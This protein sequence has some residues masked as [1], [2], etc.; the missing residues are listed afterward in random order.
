[1]DPEVTKDFEDF[2]KFV[3]SVRKLR[4]RCNA[5][6]YKDASIARAVGA[7]GIGL[8]RTEHMFFEEDRISYVIQM[9]LANDKKERQR[10][11]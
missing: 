3:D 2:M 11:L 1:V 9:I 5:D 4:G 6:T 8:C 7:E 10:A